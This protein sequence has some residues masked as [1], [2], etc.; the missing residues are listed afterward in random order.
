MN[1]QQN[2]A[3]R[4]TEVSRVMNNLSK[5]IEF[6]TQSVEATEARLTG[7]TG[8]RLESKGR[9]KVIEPEYST[10]L[11]QDIN[12]IHE[13]ILNLRERLDDLINRIEL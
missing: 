5:A 11:A 10:Q 3:V 4:E 6:L 7:V 12:K 8:S 1:N 2:I 13:R 9:D